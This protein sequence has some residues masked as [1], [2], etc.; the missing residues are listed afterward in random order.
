MGLSDTFAQRSEDIA[1]ALNDSISDKYLYDDLEATLY[2]CEFSDEL[3]SAI[4]DNATQEVF[5]EIMDGEGGTLEETL[6]QRL[7]DAF[8]D[9]IGKSISMLRNFKGDNE[10]SLQILE[11]ARRTIEDINYNYTRLLGEDAPQSAL[12]AMDGLQ[13]QLVPI[14]SLINDL[15]EQT[16]INPADIKD[17]EEGWQHI[18]QLPESVFE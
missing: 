8:R 6:S 5:Y 3:I 2:G 4:K 16:G 9:P 7:A 1:Q 17:N 11:R 15:S 14:Q 18:H 13:E 12:D 10:L